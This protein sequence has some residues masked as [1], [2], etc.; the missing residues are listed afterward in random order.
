[1]LFANPQKNE[2]TK[3]HNNGSTNIEIGVRGDYLI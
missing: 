1:M 2:K 3:T